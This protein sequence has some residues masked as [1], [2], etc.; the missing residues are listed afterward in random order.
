[1]TRYVVTVNR[2]EQIAFGLEADSQ[3]DAESRYL[4]DGDEI[5]SATISTVVVSVEESL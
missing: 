4:M 5:G 1:M 2:T 3:E